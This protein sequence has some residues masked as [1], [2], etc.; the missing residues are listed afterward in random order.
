MYLVLCYVTLH[1]TVLTWNVGIFFLRVPVAAEMGI[2]DMFV[3]R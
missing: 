1:A 3:R 2:R